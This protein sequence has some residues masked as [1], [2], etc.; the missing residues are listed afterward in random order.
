MAA[1]AQPGC[2]IDDRFGWAR[3]A[4][5]DCFADAKPASSRCERQSALWQP[6]LPV[7][8]GQR[9]SG[10]RSQRRKADLQVDRPGTR[11]T[12]SAVDDPNLPA[13]FLQSSRTLSHRFSCLASTKQP[14]VISR[15]C[16]GLWDTCPRQRQCDERR[17][18]DG[19]CR[20][21]LEGGNRGEGHC[22]R[23]GA[24][25]PLANASWPG[26]LSCIYRGGWLAL[27]TCGGDRSAKPLT[28]WPRPGS[29]RCRRGGGFSQHRF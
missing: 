12:R 23:F 17:R 24:R 9:L 18:P 21:S 26:G 28:R 4:M 6:D 14:S 13:G 29:G 10:T 7:W 16:L 15:T 27:P 11:R 25:S 20:T 1:C 5:N 2:S 22:G 19:R 8:V 3:V